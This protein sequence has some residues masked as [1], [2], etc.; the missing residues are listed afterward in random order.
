MMGKNNKQKSSNIYTMP[1]ATPVAASYLMKDGG[2]QELLDQTAMH[3]DVNYNE[4]VNAYINKIK[5]MAMEKVQE[6]M[7]NASMGYDEEAGAI[8]NMIPMAQKGMQFS[9]Q[10]YATVDA[11]TKAAKP[12]YDVGKGLMKFLAPTIFASK[13]NTTG[14]PL[15]QYGV[16]S[17]KV[18]DLDKAQ[19]GKVVGSPD[20]E[21]VNNP[22]GSVTVYKADGTTM[23]YFNKQQFQKN[24]QVPK[25]KEAQVTGALPTTLPEAGFT[26]DSARMDETTKYTFN[27]ETDKAEK[28][29]SG[30]GTTIAGNTKPVWSPEA[31]YSEPMDL[32]AETQTQT[33]T[34]AAVNTQ[35]QT[36]G[37]NVGDGYDIY[38]N[39]IPRGGQRGALMRNGVPEAFFL[40][41]S[42][43]TQVTPNYRNNLL[44]YFR[45]P[46]NERPGSLK[47]IDIDFGIYDPQADIIP[48]QKP[49]TDEVPVGLSELG[50]TR[51]DKEY[52][53]TIDT[54]SAK[55]TRRA[56]K[57]ARQQKKAEDVT[58][59]FEEKAARIANPDFFKFLKGGGLDK[60]LQ[61]AQDGKN[62]NGLT[63]QQKIQYDPDEQDM[64]DG[65]YGTIQDPILEFQP[66][67]KDQKTA[68][69][70]LEK[71]NPFAAPA[72]LAGMNFLAG[73]LE[74]ADA[75]QKQ[76][77]LMN[78]L[79][80]DQ[81]SNEFRGSEGDYAFNTGMFRPDQMVPVQFTGYNNT[82]SQMGGAFEKDTEYYLDDDTIQA[83]LAAGGEIEYL[84]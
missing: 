50:D 42:V 11:F 19:T 5:Q 79:A 39:L 29:P 18:K 7:L 4:K 14:D 83:I 77:E 33:G 38:R 81:M 15:D 68:R 34:Q 84:D 71:K 54:P 58:K 70:N 67:I 49:N 25:G 45:K 23:R 47:S 65:T 1:F 16:T 56:E 69:F 55:E 31:G 26:I 48:F 62:Q 35:D 9:N 60:F 27:R 8:M 74:N 37:Y 43:I 64:R 72:M 3:P 76:K 52:D 78:R 17:V 24:Y 75:M 61:K 57:E 28:T 10:A 40:P 2:Q 20:D 66:E 59:R 21:V 80:F 44:N 22:D 32:P 13:F 30:A 36:T 6:E 73:T 41:D 53:V 63:T 51:A 82:M 46:E 12:K